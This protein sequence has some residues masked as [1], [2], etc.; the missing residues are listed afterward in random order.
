MAVKI[1]LSNQQQ[2]NDVDFYEMQSALPTTVAETAPIKNDKM[3]SDII[4]GYATTI[5]SAIN[6]VPSIMQEQRE[7]FRTMM[8]VFDMMEQRG[9][10]T[11]NRPQAI[12]ERT[13]ATWKETLIGAAA[14]IGSAILFT[15]IV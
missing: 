7:N 2:F 3:M 10:I 11:V 14:I 5:S 1:R 4:K 6:T 12:E 15:L 13:E 9:M 8:D